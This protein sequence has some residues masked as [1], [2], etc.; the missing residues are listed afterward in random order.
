MARVVVVRSH[1][2]GVHCGRIV[3]REGDAVTLRDARRA[4]SWQGALSCSELATKGPGKGSKI[5]AKVSRVVVL[6][7]IEIIDCA[8]AASKAWADAPEAST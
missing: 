8:E 6:G 5:C 4:W 7:A 2:A 1:L 3:K